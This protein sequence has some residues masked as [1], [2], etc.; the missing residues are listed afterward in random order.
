MIKT[1]DNFLAKISIYQLTLYYLVFLVFFAIIFSLLGLLPFNWYDLLISTFFLVSIGWLVNSIFTDVFVVNSKSESVY[2][3]ALILVL[4]IS[5]ATSAHELTF[6]LW[7]VVWTVASKF[8]FAFGGK[9][10]FNPAT[11]AVFLLAITTNQSASWWVGGLPML[12][13]VLIG[14]ILVIKKFRKLELVLSFLISSV[15]TV[16][17]ATVIKGGDIILSLRNI[18]F[19]SAWLFLAFVMLTEPKTIPITKTSQIVYG[20]IIG[21]LF[22]PQIHLSSFYTTPEAAIVIGNIYSYLANEI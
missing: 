20:V 18:L 3:S 10:I 19:H 8:I 17:V 9:H 16:L 4:I 2:I 22:A 5:P 15:M 14:G 21:F 1:I 11:L 7:A 6:L 12:P 13:L